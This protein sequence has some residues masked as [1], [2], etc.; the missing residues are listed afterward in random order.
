MAVAPRPNSPASMYARKYHP[1]STSMYGTN[2]SD[3]NPL[4]ITLLRFPV[5]GS[6]TVARE[7]IIPARWSAFRWN[8]Q[9]AHFT[10]YPSSTLK[11]CPFGCSM[12]MGFNGSTP[13][14]R[15]STPSRRPEPSRR[16]RAT[17]HVIDFDP[18]GRNR[19]SEYQIRECGL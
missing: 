11:L 3:A 4:Y 5:S 13:G 7:I 16:G 6:K 2:N 9:L 1:S 14:A 8:S 18:S 12:E 15:Y 10:I 17:N 19:L